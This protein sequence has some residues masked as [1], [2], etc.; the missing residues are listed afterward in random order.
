MRY[1][2]VLDRPTMDRVYREIGDP[3]RLAI[4]LADYDQVGDE[5]VPR[6]PAGSA[7]YVE[8]VR[9]QWPGAGIAMYNLQQLSSQQSET[10]KRTV[11]QG[12]AHPGI[13]SSSR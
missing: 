12:A 11:F 3:Q 9:A 2:R 10:L 13:G 1:G 6:N 5:V 8:L 7:K 4:M